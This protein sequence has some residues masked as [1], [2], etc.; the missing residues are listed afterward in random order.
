MYRNH[1]DICKFGEKDEDDFNDVLHA[2]RRMVGE[3]HRTSLKRP[4]DSVMS[5]ACT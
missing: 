5:E 3:M 4:T 1:R 2:I